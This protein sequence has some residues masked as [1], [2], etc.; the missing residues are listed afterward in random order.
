MPSDAAPIPTH[1]SVF[2]VVV[3]DHSVD[4]E[5]LQQKQVSLHTNF[6][7][8]VDIADEWDEAPFVAGRRLADALVHTAPF[9]GNSAVVAVSE[10]ATIVDPAAVSMLRMNVLYGTNF[11]HGLVQARSRNPKRIVL[12]A[13]SAPT[14]HWDGPGERDY[15]FSWPPT[16]ETI[17]RTKRELDGAVNDGVQI[18]AVLIENPARRENHSWTGHLHQI[19]DLATDATYR[20]HGLLA[21]IPTPVSDRDITDIV[22]AIANSASQ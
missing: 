22:N 13:Y 12:I 9:A 10:F 11:H 5:L 1:D 16:P 8:G 15:F 18:D 6:G 21:H 7:Y 19:N 20:S 4:M 3:L 17:D 14:A 2:G